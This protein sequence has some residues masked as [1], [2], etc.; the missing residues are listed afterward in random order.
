MLNVNLYVLLR[1]I[2]PCVGNGMMMMMM[3]TAV[4]GTAQA[5]RNCGGLM[6][7]PAG[8]PWCRPTAGGLWGVNRRAR[9]PMDHSRAAATPAGG[10]LDLVT[11][12]HLPF[13]MEIVMWMTVLTPPLQHLIHHRPR[14]KE[15]RGGSYTYRAAVVVCNDG[16]IFCLCW[17][18]I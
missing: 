7:K 1:L 9:R 6:K 13:M 10:P 17:V 11:T 16:G 14:T 12:G 2:C 15:G 18:R 8:V 5:W 3:M 4:P